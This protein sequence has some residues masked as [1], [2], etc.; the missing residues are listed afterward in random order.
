M[1]TPNPKMLPRLDELEED[2]L[3]RRERA[4]AEDWRGEIDGIDLTLSFLRSKR[5][6]VA[7]F[8]RHGPVSLGLPTVPPQGKQVKGS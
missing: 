5:Q 8:E 4:F 3:A 6:Q 7:R 2:L 1:L